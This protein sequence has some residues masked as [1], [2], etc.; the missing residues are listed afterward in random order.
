MSLDELE[1]RF[2]MMLG[3]TVQ[4]LVD[5]HRESEQPQCEFMTLG[6]A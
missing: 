3:D 5:L 6:A 2:S 4:C 1:V